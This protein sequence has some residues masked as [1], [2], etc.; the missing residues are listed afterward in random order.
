MV[1]DAARGGHMQTNRKLKD[2]P[3]PISNYGTVGCE[4]TILMP[5][6]NEAETLEKCVRKAQLFLGRSKVLGE[7]IVADNGSTDG[8]QSIAEALGARVVSVTQRGYGAALLGGIRAARG[9]YIVM[10]DS[11][12]SYDFA[13]LGPFLTKLRDGYDLVIGNRFRGGIAAGAMPPLHRFLGNPVLSGIGRLFFR[14][15]IGDFHCGLRAFRREAIDILELR[16]AGMEFASE[17]IVKATLK[18]L[19]ITEVPTFLSADGRSRKPHLRSWRDGWRHLRFLFMYAPRWLFLYPGLLLVLA[20]FGM[21]ALVLPGPLTLGSVV[22]DVHTLIVAMT[23]VLVGSQTAI[24][25]FMAKRF[26]I[27]TGNIQV[28]PKLT[29]ILRLASLERAVS[30]GATLS[31]LGIGGMMWAVSSWANVAF[32]ELD[33]E[34]MMRLVIPSATAIGLG[35]QMIFAAFLSSILEMKAN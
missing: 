8:S 21:M 34:W 11:D 33:Y 25:F 10:G 30:V 7:V 22:F 5:C 26:A 3:C 16:T 29:A 14:S 12:D 17:M 4:L 18:G 31:L 6:L 27:T 23:A 19:R 35:V 9:R 15:P 2:L 1:G 20:G 13:D 32:G 28:A 24:Y